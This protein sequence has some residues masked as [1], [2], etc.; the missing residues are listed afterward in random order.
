VQ[1]CSLPNGFGDFDFDIDQARRDLAMRARFLKS[2]FAST[3]I[4]VVIPSELVEQAAVG[5]QRELN[6]ALRIA[7]IE[8]LNQ[9]PLA[10]D[11]RLLVQES[12]VEAR[13]ICDTRYHANAQA[14][15]WRTQ[16]LIDRLGRRHAVPPNSVPRE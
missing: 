3:M 6:R 8:R 12:F 1:R 11:M 14:R 13:Q 7:F 16:G 5:L 10:A 9:E 15:Q 4:V 2:V